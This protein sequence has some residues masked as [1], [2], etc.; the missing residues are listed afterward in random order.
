MGRTR[1]P[2]KSSSNK[3]VEIEGEVVH[4]TEKA[5]LFNVDG[6]EEWVPKSQIEEEDFEA[7]DSMTIT[8][9]E[10]L[11]KVKGWSE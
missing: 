10:W 11:A 2:D 3:T 7:G 1:T 4:E 5:I 6:I 8:I 9:P